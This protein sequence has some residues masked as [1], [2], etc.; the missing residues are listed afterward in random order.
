MTRKGGP[1]R[2]RGAREGQ[3][4]SGHCCEPRCRLPA[5]RVE[6]GAAIGAIGVSILVIV[7][8]R[9]GSLIVCGI[10]GRVVIVAGP[11]IVAVPADAKCADEV[12]VAMPAM[13]I[14]SMSGPV[15]S[16]NDACTGRHRREAAANGVAAHSRAVEGCDVS[17]TE[18][19]D[20]SAMEST[21]AAAME[22]SNAAAM[23]ATHAA[24][25]MAAA[26]PAAMAKGHRAG[27]HR[28]CEGHGHRTCDKL[29]PHRN[30]LYFASSPID[31]CRI[32]TRA[33]EWLRR[34]RIKSA[35]LFVMIERLLDACG[36]RQSVNGGCTL[37]IAIRGLIFALV[38]P[39]LASRRPDVPLP[40][41]LA[42]T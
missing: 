40:A 8:G 20:V 41:L 9:A 23:K 32:T 24:A 16:G 33:I 39:V 15:M 38:P 3:P 35:Q 14:P 12:P 37:A 28:C 29:F 7:I 21:D 25:A 5:N 26:T 17:A 27:R 30:L 18:S 19:S 11:V 22:G 10:V 2:E 34:I 42:P 36:G 4:V 6:A 13:S 31:T 1:E